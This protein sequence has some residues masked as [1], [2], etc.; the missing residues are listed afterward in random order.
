MN[1]HVLFMHM[2]CKYKIEF[3]W[4]FFELSEEYIEDFWVSIAYT[5]V[6]TA[7]KVLSKFCAHLIAYL[8]P[9]QKKVFITQ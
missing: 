3:I 9:L 2:F 6:N 1:K 4:I 7:Y 5:N 8:S